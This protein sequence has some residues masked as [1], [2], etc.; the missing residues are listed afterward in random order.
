MTFVCLANFPKDSV[1][2][3]GPF[4]RFEAAFEDIYAAVSSVRISAGSCGVCS[5]DSVCVWF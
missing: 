2:V 4:L 3:L 5:A 1:S